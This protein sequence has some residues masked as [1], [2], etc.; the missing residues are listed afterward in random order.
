MT[1]RLPFSPLVWGL[2][3][4]I[5]LCGQAS[6]CRASLVGAGYDL[7]ATAPSSSDDFG[8][9]IGIQSLVGDPLDYSTFPP[10]VPH[11]LP[12]GSTDTIVQRLSSVTP[13]PGGGTTDLQVDALQLETVNPIP[14]LGNQHLFITL[15]P[16]AMENGTMTIYSNGAFTSTLDLNLDIHL[17]SLTGTVI[18]S[19]T[20]LVLTNSGYAWGNTAPPE[21]VLI[22]GVNYLLNV[23]VVKV[24]DAEFADSD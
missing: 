13:S 23:C 4:G 5:A 11:P 20:D 8:G 12:V 7:F 15:T 6:E 2:A 18:G 14:S 19:L 24:I 21:A 9:T 16:G 10:I 3:V 22:P 17:G 1:H